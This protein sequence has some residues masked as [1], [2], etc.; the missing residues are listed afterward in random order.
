VAHKGNLEMTDQPDGNLHAGARLMS[1]PYIAE[2]AQDSL[3]LTLF[4]D[5]IDPIFCSTERFASP[6]GLPE[7]EPNPENSFRA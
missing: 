4:H 2:N 5:E 3:G 7:W 1:D 6:R